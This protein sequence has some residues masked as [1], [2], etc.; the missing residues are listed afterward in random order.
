V[1]CVALLAL[2]GFAR[3]EEVVDQKN[4]PV[5]TDSYHCGA[6]PILNKSISQSFVPAQDNVTAV[7]LRLRAGTAFPSTDF[8]TTIR[9]RAGSPTGTVL[10]ESSAEVPASQANLAQV[11]VRFDFDDVALTPGDTYLLEWDTPDNTILSW[12]GADDE[13][14]YSAG[15]AYSCA[16]TVW[17]GGITD[18]SFITYATVESAD[19]GGLDGLAAMVEKMTSGRTESRLLRYLSIAA[20]Y[21][22]R[23]R[24]GRAAIRLRIFQVRVRVYVRIGRISAADGEKLMDAADELADG[25]FDTLRKSWFVRRWW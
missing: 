9:I 1:V 6:P 5:S 7:E 21:Q 25:W 19:A 24:L 14:R 8:K 15:T 13:D 2:A 22:D 17:K 3:A 23:G 12:M 11:L 18:F 10:A 16:G 20:Y 4:D